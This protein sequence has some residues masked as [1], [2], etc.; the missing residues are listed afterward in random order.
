LEIMSDDVP[1]DVVYLRPRQPP[2]RVERFA[3]TETGSSAWVT[4]DKTGERWRSQ[5]ST[6]I[7]RAR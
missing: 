7:D 5:I 1:V 4:L 6:I 3:P 2:A